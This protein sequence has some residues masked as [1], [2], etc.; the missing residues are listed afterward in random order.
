MYSYCRIAVLAAL[1]GIPVVGNAAGVDHPQRQGLPTLSELEKIAD[2]AIKSVDQQLADSRAR[3]AQIEAGA[4]R[5]TGEKHAKLG[6]KMVKDAISGATKALSAGDLSKSEAGLKGKDVVRGKKEQ[7][8]LEDSFTDYVTRGNELGRL[9]DQRRSLS[10][11]R[12]RLSE[13]KA[14]II[15]ARVDI[16]RKK[17]AAKALAEANAKAKAS[18]P[19]SP[20]NQSN[21]VSRG[22]HEPH[23]HPSDFRDFGPR[24]T[25]PKDTGPR[26]TG[27][28]DTGPKDTGPRDT[29]SRE[30]DRGPEMPRQH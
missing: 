5:E 1:L 24:D 25:G 30:S 9:T 10:R 27:P 11:L 16:Q 4:S 20:T 18:T 12:G 7:Q 17:A 6:A 21:N 28:K 15:Q 29:G 23:D 3:T 22:D 26:D 8:S 2:R 13:L 14:A 19:A